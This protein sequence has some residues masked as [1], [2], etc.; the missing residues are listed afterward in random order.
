MRSALVSWSPPER[1]E[2]VG[3][4][5]VTRQPARLANGSPGFVGRRRPL[6]RPEVGLHDHGVFARVEIVALSLAYHTEAK[7]L[8]ETERLDVGG[9]DLEKG[10]EHTPG[11]PLGEDRLEQRP[12]DPPTPPLRMDG[13]VGDVDLVADLPETEVAAEP[14]AGPG[15]HAASDPVLGELVAE[16]GAR[17]RGLEGDTL[18]GQDIVEVVEGH[19]RQGQ[20]RPRLRLA[21]ARSRSPD[22]HVRSPRLRLRLALARSRSP[23]PHVRS[24]RLRLRLALARSRSPDPHVRSPRLR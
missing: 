18:D 7:T 23:D 6:R 4:H 5:V 2:V 17:P 14:R 3:T 22:P 16:S 12:G 20:R 9:S 21:L 10:E 11:P 24:P 8:V 1:D 15:D 19:G 13:Q